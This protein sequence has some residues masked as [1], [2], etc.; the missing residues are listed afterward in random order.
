MSALP[1]ASSATKPLILIASPSSDEH[2]MYAEYFVSLG[3]RVATTT[4]G[5]D[6]ITKARA[7]APAVVVASV[8]LPGRDGIEVSRALQ[9]VNIPV[10]L[11]ASV[12]FFRTAPCAA[13]MLRPALPHE[14]CAIVERLL[15]D[16]D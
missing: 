8:Q 9:E 7:L 3:F 13:V 11:L 16:K 14:V 4:R 12:P 1:V 2:A 6:T 15:S 10:I 5:D